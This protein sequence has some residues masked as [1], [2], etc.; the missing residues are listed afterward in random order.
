MKKWYILL[1]LALVTTTSFAQT[2]KVR[3]NGNVVTKDKRIEH[4]TKVEIHSDLEVSILHNPFANKLSITG[5]ANLH[6]IIETQVKDGI[7]TLKL[8]DNFE[9]VEQT[10]P[11]KIALTTKDLNEIHIVGNANVESIG[12]NESDT[13]VITN[14]GSGN[15]ELRVKNDSLKVTNTGSG[16][17]VAEGNANIITATN[18]SSGLVDLRNVSTFFMEVMASGSGDTYTNAVNG[19]DGKLEGSGNIYYRN[20]KTLNVNVTG[21]GELKRL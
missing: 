4:F 3:G 18:T 8:K 5:D 20:T 16:T 14:S 17:I 6:Q 2:R 11:F 10:S 15:I 12:T 1:L 9:V 19:L 7:L 13:L 21:S